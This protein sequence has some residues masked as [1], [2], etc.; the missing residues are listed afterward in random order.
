MAQISSLPKPITG[1]FIFPDFSINDQTTLNNFLDEIKEL[2]MDTL[3]WTYTGSVY[4][5][6]D[7]NQ[8]YTYDNFFRSNHA[9]YLENPDKLLTAAY[10]KG[11]SVYVGLSGTWSCVN[12]KNSDDQVKIKELS[13]DLIDDLKLLC[14]SKGW[15]CQSN[16][17][18]KGYY[19]PIEYS[20]KELQGP[21]FYTTLYN[22]IKAKDPT[23]KV[24]ISPYTNNTYD[25]ESKEDAHNAGINAVR[26]SYADIIAL[27]DSVGSGKVDN[28]WSDRDHFLGLIQGVNDENKKLGKSVEVW[29]NVEAFHG[30]L[31]SWPPWP[32]T[33]I[34]TLTWQ[35][36]AIDDLV[37][38]KITWLYNWSFATLPLLNNF[39]GNFYKPYLATARAKLR[40]DYLNKPIIVAAITWY[41]PTNF[42]VKGYNF[43]QN[44]ES[45]D[46]YLHYGGKRFHTTINLD[47]VSSTVT[48]VRIPLDSIPNFNPNNP[49]YVAIKNSESS[50][51]YYNSSRPE[52][53]P[54][55]D[56]TEINNVA[57]PGLISNTV[58]PTNLSPNQSASI[59]CDYGAVLDCIVPANP[60][61]NCTWTGTAG[62]KANFTCQ[63]PATGGSYTNA[64]KLISG[65]NSN[66]CSKTSNG[67][68]FTVE[69]PPSL[70]KPG[71][72]NHNGKVN[73]D[74]YHLLMS[75]FIN[76]FDFNKL[77]SNFGK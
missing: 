75:N 72:L 40:S 66:C 3:I 7:C 51:G 62:T 30:P 23:K 42:V 37:P 68:T 44:G 14:Q 6:P 55:G 53:S 10:N 63:A 29:A 67:V 69:G 21:N 49:F 58:S 48:E 60:W 8:P 47:S 15:D 71:D 9:N 70:P 64:C 33:D 13:S 54:E 38:K 65:T 22:M 52:F 35:I 50:V 61:Q 41:T 16:N 19:L 12:P 2:G 4:K 43:G 18:I 17:F 25:P 5:T 73:L 24:M 34:Y 56:F 59:T 27:Q 1:T 39:G 57:C 31:D 36:R 77:I 74:D 11:F 76:I 46:L 20:L 28:Y 32:P 26:Y 45:F